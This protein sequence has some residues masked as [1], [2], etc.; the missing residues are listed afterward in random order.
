MCAPASSMQYCAA[1]PPVQQTV[2]S[3]IAPV[4]CRLLNSSRVGTPAY[5]A[6]LATQQAASNASLAAQ[7]IGVGNT[8]AAASFVEDSK[9]AAAQ[10]GVYAGQNPPAQG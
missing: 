3:S 4:C 9:N 5:D 2:L 1:P 8:T 10:A 6:G 7:A